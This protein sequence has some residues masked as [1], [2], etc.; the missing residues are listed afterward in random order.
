MP[1]IPGSH[2]D[3][4]F[5]VKKVLKLLSPEGPLSLK[6]KSFEVRPEQQTMLTRLLEAFNSNAIALIEAGTGIGKSLAY[7][8]PALLAAAIWKEKVVIS[9]HTISLQ[10]QLLHKDLPILMD[11]LR[12]ELKATLVKGMGNYVCLRKIDEIGFEKNFLN[13]DEK[14]QLDQIEALS[15]EKGKGSRSD[16]PF[17][18]PTRLWEMVSAEHDSCNGA[19]CPHYHDCHFMQA[20]KNAHDSQILI[21]NHHLLLADLILRSEAQNYHS[22]ALLP[23]FKRIVIDE[24]HHLEDIATEYFATRISRLELFKIVSK[25]SS[26]KQGRAVGK[27]SQV[28]EKVQKY[29]THD[30]SRTTSQFLNYLTIDLPALRRDLLKELGDA[31]GL[32]EKFQE[33]NGI[34]S[35]GDENK[36]RLRTHHYEEKNWKEQII[37]QTRRLSHALKRYSGELYRLEPYVKELDNGHLI[38][39]LKGILFDIKTLAKKLENEASNLEAFANVPPSQDSIRWLEFSLT[40]HGLNISCKDAA[41]NISNK[42]SEYL[43]KPFDTVALLSATLTAQ[44]SFEFVKKR[45]GLVENNLNSRPLIEAQFDS[46]FD[47][48]KQALLIIPDNIPAP[49]DIKFLEK[50]HELIWEAIQASRGN[51][52]ILF[53]SYE[54]LNSCYQALEAPMRKHKFLPLKQGDDNRQ[55]LLKKFVENSGSILF[56]TDSFWEGI[57]VVGEALRLVIIA[58]LPFK[59]PSDPLIEAR[60]EFL[61]AQGKDPFYELLLPDAAIKLKQGFGRLIRNKKDRGCVVCLDNRLITKNYGKFFLKTLPN[62]PYAVVEQAAFKSTISE[63]YQKTYYLTKS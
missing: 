35:L 51:A 19:D 50:A 26:E 7:L 56:G 1:N 31:F 22:S 54:M 17:N 59:V 8:I 11:V 63:F 27:L 46:P 52:F 28:K 5:D 41:L 53:T 25:I 21:V 30:F 14:A 39:S 45:L 10:E 34:N 23:P 61:S 29:I 57:D 15:K 49:T 4:P 40:P 44:N 2:Q 37:P 32:F 62:C 38:E 18:P 6:L 42:I 60:S 43:F 33:R 58:K 24:A 13:N 16:L 9:T 55:N 20:R 12:T 36:F 48:Q 47:Y 3:P